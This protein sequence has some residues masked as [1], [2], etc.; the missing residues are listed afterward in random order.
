[1]STILL[2]AKV[3]NIIKAI[4]QLCQSLLVKLLEFLTKLNLIRVLSFLILKFTFSCTFPH[5]RSHTVFF[6]DRKYLK[7]RVLNHCFS[8]SLSASVVFL[9]VL[10]RRRFDWIILSGSLLLLLIVIEFHIVCTWLVFGIGS[11]VALPFI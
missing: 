7:L 9:R 10:Q 6:I 8:Q 2:V 11:S 5:A 1:M 3:L 4:C